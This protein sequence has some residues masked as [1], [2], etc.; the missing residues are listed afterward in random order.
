[1]NDSNIQALADLQ[2]TLLPY[3]GYFGE[4]TRVQAFVVVV[5][6]FFIAWIFNRIV[7]N[8]LKKIAAKSSFNIDNQL[9]DLFH[10]ELPK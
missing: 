5:A 1:M 2:T 6:S 9:I 3:L 4:N 10:K 7:I 8:F